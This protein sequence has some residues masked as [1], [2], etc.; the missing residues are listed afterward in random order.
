MASPCQNRYPAVKLPH[1]FLTSYRVNTVANTSPSTLALSLDGQPS[2]GRSPPQP[3]HSDALSWLELTQLPENE[4][5]S[6]SDNGPWARA[7]RSP[8]TTFQW[9]GD[10]PPS[11]GQIWNVIH[12]IYL[13]QPTNEYFRLSLS[14]AGKN[15]VRTEL[16]TTGLAVEHPKQRRP[17]QPTLLRTEPFSDELLIL[18]SSFWQG[19]ASP[20]GPRP[21][22]V[23]GDGTDGPLRAPLAQY[24]IMPENYQTTNK[25]PEQPIYTRHPT[26]R[27]KPHPGSIVYSRYVPGIDQ[28]FSLE[29]VDWQSQEHLALFNKWQNDPRV[30]KGWN[31]TGDLDHHQKYLRDL[32]EDPHVLSLFGR[33]DNAR[34]AYFELYWAKVCHQPLFTHGYVCLLT[35][36]PRRT[37]TATTPKRAITT[38]GATRSWETS[39]SAV[40]RE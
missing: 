29:A 11:L 33:F 20:T 4:H 27:P 6:P 31:E 15:V 8:A 18:R 12:A 34:F 38:A 3:L 14:G 35:P 32:H 9:K 2:E 37:T 1:P 13:G 40:R 7:R 28:H 5:P 10:S 25:F 21:I 17:D 36:F 39:R 24:P 23:L 19:A 16:L 30:A 22:W 26:R